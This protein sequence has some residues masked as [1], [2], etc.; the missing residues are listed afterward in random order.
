MG[1]GRGLGGDQAPQLFQQLHTALN[2]KEMQEME[3]VGTGSQ[4]NN[5][6]N[7]SFDACVANIGLWLQV[8]FT[9]LIYR[10]N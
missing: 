9:L 4:E 1:G 8:N 7:P 6:Q 3:G 5:N 10:P 2:E